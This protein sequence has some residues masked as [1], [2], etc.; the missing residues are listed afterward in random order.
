MIRYLS[1]THAIVIMVNAI[2]IKLTLPIAFF[3][4]TSLIAEEKSIMIATVLKALTNIGIRVVS[5]TSDGLSTNP[6]SYEILGAIPDETGSIR[7]YFHNPDN[8]Q[9]IYVF[10]DTPHMLKLT[11]NCLGA[12]KVLHSSNKPIKWQ[13]IERLYR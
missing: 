11:R 2:N 6:A 8:E 3:F 13:Y 4:I 10:Y 12:K 5:I 7:P 9:R 1:V